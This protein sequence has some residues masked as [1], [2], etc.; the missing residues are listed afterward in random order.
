MNFTILLFLY[1]GSIYVFLKEKIVAHLIKTVNQ[2]HPSGAKNVERGK[3]EVIEGKT[4]YPTN[5]CTR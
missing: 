2:L 5:P 4:V 1:N 3:E